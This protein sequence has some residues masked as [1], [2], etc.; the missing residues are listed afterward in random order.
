[1]FG[2]TRKQKEQD[3]WEKQNKRS[4]WDQKPKSSLFSK[5]KPPSLFSN[6]TETIQGIPK[7]N[8]TFLQRLKIILFK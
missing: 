4:K 1:M 8:Y 5:R 3:Q 6:G 2:K 7:Y